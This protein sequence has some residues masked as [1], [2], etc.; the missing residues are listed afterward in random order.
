MSQPP[1]AAACLYIPEEA[2]KLLRSK[3]RTLER[4]RSTGTGPRYIKVGRRVVYRL[5]DLEVWL[6]Q[7]AREHTAERGESNQ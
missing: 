3:S 2:A 1:I 5:A 7:Q 4:W 6:E